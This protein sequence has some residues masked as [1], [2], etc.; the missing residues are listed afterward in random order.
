[1]NSPRLDITQIPGKIGI[2]QKPP[3]TRISQPQADLEIKQQQGNLN[4]KKDSVEIKVDNY[5]SRYDLGYRNIE[6]MLKDI[7]NKGQQVASEKAAE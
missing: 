2:N 6:D 3:S 7:K 1:M 5:P 4:I